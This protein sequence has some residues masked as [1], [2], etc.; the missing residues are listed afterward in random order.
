MLI[1]AF[2]LLEKARAELRRRLG[3][4]A[5]LLPWLSFAYGIVSGVTITRD[6]AHS[7]SLVRWFVTLIVV[8]IALRAFTYV[9]REEL[10]AKLGERFGVVRHLLDRP[11]LIQ[12]L[13]SGLTQYSVQYIG[14]F[15]L[16]LLFFAQA[17]W[18]FGL[19][20]LV[21]GT[22]LWDSW[23]DRLAPRFWYLA[24]IRAVSAVLAASF[25]F[26]VLLPR[27]L[28]W[29]HPLCAAAAAA[30][31]LPWHRLSSRTRPERRE[32]LPF[33]VVSALAVYQASTDAWLRVPLL[34]VWLKAP[35]M[36]VGIDH[37][38]LREPWHAEV[39]RERLSL[40]LSLGQDVCCITPVVSPSGVLAKVIHEWRADGRI[41][42]RI[43]LPEI[44]GGGGPDGL[45]PFRT[46]S[47]KKH[48]P[49]PSRT[50]LLECLVY[51]EPAIYL[52]RVRLVLAG[53]AGVKP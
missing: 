1:R 53:N 17:W 35:Q 45:A 46:F 51:L 30:A 32:L 39:S 37:R 36:G 43:S 26:A 24:L 25:T 14:M 3:R 16:P 34:S 38:K 29:F 10:G 28:A 6:F 50:G 2:V 21:V 4:R 49:P 42:D 52:G 8:S 12:G 33:L 44:R 22:T 19:T 13:G 48:L 15:C 11:A 18:T 9:Q 40:A 23:W 41:I 20:L 27:Q 47:C 31:V 7:S 5:Y